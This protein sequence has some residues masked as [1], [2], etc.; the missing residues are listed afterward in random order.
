MLKPLLF[1]LMVGSTIA[2]FSFES[3]FEQ[4]QSSNP[5][6]LKLSK[7][8]DAQEINALLTV[9]ADRSQG[10]APDSEFLRWIA[11][12]PSFEPVWQAVGFYAKPKSQEGFD[13]R[14]KKNAG[15]VVSA[16]NLNLQKEFFE[17]H[18]KLFFRL[19]KH[20]GVKAEIL[21]ALCSMETR[22]NR[23]RLPHLA[24]AVFATQ[25]AFFKDVFGLRSEFL[26]L[27]RV[28]RLMRM[29]RHN[30]VSLYLYTSENRI[31]IEEIR[32]SWAGACGPMQFLP[33][34]FHYLED[35]DLDGDID[36]RKVD[37]A[38]AGAANFL[39]KKG[40]TRRHNEWFESGE[41]DHELIKV[42]KR[43][44]AN[45]EY[46]LGVL[47][48]ARLLKSLSVSKMMEKTKLSP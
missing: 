31:S 7:L 43:Y 28:E 25:L 45:D 37:D 9:L 23:A 24:Y 26:D 40:W 10:K 2:A 44:N 4:F 46:A 35:G 48:S 11:E 47:N 1:L 12:L 27:Q 16:S 22:L 34:N 13:K 20:Y 5:S 30:I 19:E 8:L 3:R 21:V 29:A 32:S 6:Q 41:S 38:L 33:F 39:Q 14:N 36:L 15:A 18:K 17:K 42:L